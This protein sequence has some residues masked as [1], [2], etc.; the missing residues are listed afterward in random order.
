[1]GQRAHAHRSGGWFSLSVGF[2]VGGKRYDLLPILAGL[3][4]NDFL[5]ETLDRP[6]NGHVYAP[7]PDG[8]ALRLP[9]GRVRRILQ[10][11]ASLIDPKFPDRAK[12]HA[13][14]AAAL[15]GLEGLGIEPP[16]DLAELAAKLQDFSGIEPVRT[17][18]RRAGHAARLSA[19]GLP[20]D[21]VS[22]PPR[23]ARHPRR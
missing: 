21:A 10:H 4:E 11:L 13:L 23:P 16:P 18:G 2:D 19:R 1:M 22:R 12:L 20:L 6:D 7:L 17:A 3:L 5:E 8:D 15:A 9:I 14:D